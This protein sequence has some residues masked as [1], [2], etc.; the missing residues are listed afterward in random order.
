MS[1]PQPTKARIRRV[2]LAGVDLQRHTSKIEINESICKS[3]LTGT[4]TIIDNNNLINSMALSGGEPCYISFDGGGGHVYSC[5]LHLLALK[6]ETSNQNGRAQIYTADLIG[7][8]YFGD[9]KNIVQQSFKTTGSNAIAAIHS[10]YI[11]GSV[12]ILSQTLG[13]LSQDQSYIVSG[14]KPFKAI[15]DIAKRGKVAGFNTGT[16]LYYRDAAGVKLQ[17]LE[18]MFA[19]MEV[20][21]VFLQ[22]ATWGKDWFDIVRAQN[23]I[24]AARAEID[25]SRNGRGGMSRISSM[26]SQ[27]KTIFDFR[28]KL[29][30]ITKA[31]KISPGALIG[32]AGGL[33]AGIL[34]TSAGGHGGEQNYHVMDGSH[35][36]TGANDPS[37][38][39]S[40]LYAA[41]INNGPNISIKVPIQSGIVC[42]VGKGIEARLLPPV[43][44]LG[45]VSGDNKAS[46]RHLVTDLCHEVTQD[47]RSCSATT[48]LQCARGGQN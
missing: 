7:P 35:S 15:N 40:R 47:D 44:D 3:Y 34:G 48:T 9:R 32:Q 14:Q 31:A 16:L 36:G 13:M 24:I 41:L 22:E 21:N 27:E 30:T 12:S 29:E 17:A 8:E 6:G 37:A 38:P 5:S 39:E 26:A 25:S 28:T 19:R 11:G 18:Q 23:S 2:N 1:L 10:K 20:Q 4:L 46:G 42:T 43:G 45:R 33:A